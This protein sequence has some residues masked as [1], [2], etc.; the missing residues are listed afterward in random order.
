MNA[1]TDVKKLVQQ[2]QRYEF[3]DGLRDFQFALMM[4]AGGFGYWLVFDQMDRWMSLMIDL[5]NRFGYLGRWSL[6]LVALIPGILALAA[7]LVIRYLRRRW[8][9]RA[10]G[11]VKPA[12]WMVPRRVTLISLVI[13]AVGLVAG[14]LL[15]MAALT[16][17]MFLLRILIVSSGWSF[18]YTLA[19]MGRRLDLPR[20]IRVGLLT[21]VATTPLLFLPLTV[22]QTGLVWGLLWGVALTISGLGPLLETLRRTGDLQDER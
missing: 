21:S 9:W 20:Y 10:S 3:S 1:H 8:L 16:D 4:A 2:T 22:G 15:Q 14:I 19:E 6:I 5:A 7:L 11:Y 17:D 12:R 13:M 18:G